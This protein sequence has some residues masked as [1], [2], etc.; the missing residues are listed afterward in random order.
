MTPP[1][2]PPS[3]PSIP[4]TPSFLPL[5]PGSSTIHNL[6]CG[7]AL[8]QGALLVV[9]NKGADHGWVLAE[10]MEPLEE[11]QAATRVQR[12][13]APLTHLALA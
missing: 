6:S 5:L 11:P 12:G 9:V 4:S 7:G 13:L 3:I 10:L 2:S 1:S 8:L